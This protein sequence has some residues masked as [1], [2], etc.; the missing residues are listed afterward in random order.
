MSILHHTILQDTSI[1]LL[2]RP[3]R[4]LIEYFSTFVQ[5]RDDRFD[6]WVKDT[7]LWRNM[8]NR[9]QDTQN[10]DVSESLEHFWVLYW[11]KQW[12]NQLDKLSQEHLAAYLQ[13]TCYWAIQSIVVN[14]ASVQYKSSDCFQIA[15]ADLFNILK[16]YSPSQGASLKTYAKTSFS[17]T[18]RDVLRQRREADGRSDWGLLRKVSQKQL[19]EAL[20]AGGDSPDTIAYYRLA[21]TC[22]KTFCAPT[23]ATTIRRLPRPDLAT[24]DAIATLYNTQ[25]LHLSIPAPNGNAASLEKWMIH[26]AGRIRTLLNPS[27]TS[28]NIHQFDPESDEVVDNLPDRSGGSPLMDLISLEEL[29]ERQAQRSQVAMV[30]TSAIQELD[31]EVQTLLA[32]YYTQGLTQ[33]EIAAQF[34]MKQ[35]TISRRIS[36]AKE[37]LLLALA[38]WSQETLHITLTSPVVKQMSIV[39]EEW[40]QNL[41]Q[42]SD[43]A[44]KDCFNDA[45][46]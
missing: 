38:R 39:L 12:Q 45:N 28:L 25:R 13:E 33:Q 32:L 24:W 37:K 23:D 26:C 16:G 21:W 20:E 5:F 19:V 11:Y 42:R 40:L 41:G 14:L 22:F 7:R 17:N 3:R 15:I 6:G 4:S 44:S 10:S 46:I 34:N 43:A 18:V 1:C 27:V 30:L 31:V 2:M 9:L 35:Y 36:G 8:Q 29:Q